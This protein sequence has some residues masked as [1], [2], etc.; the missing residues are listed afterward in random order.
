MLSS[1]D[2]NEVGLTPKRERNMAITVENVSE[3]AKLLNIPSER[4]FKLV[5]SESG[6]VRTEERRAPRKPSP[7]RKIG[8]D[9]WD[10]TDE[11]QKGQ[12]REMVLSVI[13]EQGSDGINASELRDKIRERSNKFLTAQQLRSVVNALKDGEKVVREGKTRGTTYKDVQYLQQQQ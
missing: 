13:R 7:E 3:A 2:A 9:T 11:G 1:E 8:E 4:L 12:L 5:E 6:I 10:L